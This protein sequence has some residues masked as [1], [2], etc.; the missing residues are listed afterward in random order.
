MPSNNS[1]KHARE[2]GVGGSGR[3]RRSVCAPA[4]LLT[5]NPSSGK[6]TLA[7]AVAAAL[8]RQDIACEVLDG[9]ELRQRLPPSPDSHAAAG[10][11]RWSGRC[12]S[13]RCSQATA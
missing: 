6:S 3:P 2:A 1:R 5:G 10:A 9:D 13:R 8:D 7:V 4:L 12:F 11:S